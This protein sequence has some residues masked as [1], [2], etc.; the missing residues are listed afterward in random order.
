V[1]SSRK[2]PFFDLHSSL[3]PIMANLHTA[4]TDVLADGAFVGGSAVA[5]FEAEFAEF[6]SA[7]HCVGVANG[8]DALELVLQGL[9]IGPGDEVVVPANTFVATAEAVVNVGA[10]VA[11]A[12]IDPDTL[13]LRPCDVEPLINDRTA[14]IMAVHLF[15]QM[16]DMVGL[17]ELAARKGIALIEDAAQA[18]GASVDGHSPGSLSAAATFSFYPGKNLGALGDGGA[19]VTNDAELANSIRSLSAHGR[20][21]EDRYL[22]DVVG[23]NSRLDTMQAA[24]LSLRLSRLEGENDHRRLVRELY[25]EEL[26]SPVAL[27]AQAPG[28]VCANHL[29]VAQVDNR[30]EFRKELAARGIATGVHYPRP[31]HLQRPY[32]SAGGPT[33]MPVAEAAAGRIVSLPVWGQMPEDDVLYVCKQVEE[34]VG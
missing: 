22:H 1:N 7:A 19:V 25:V 26:P 2:V 18:H 4:W 12:D 13:L 23:R 6:N 16:C 30:D 5:V 10:T 11:F 20:S 17:A 14:A 27:V 34:L 9:G 21:L 3:E 15:G 29:I 24:F 31:C 8:T 33:S 32:V 28:R